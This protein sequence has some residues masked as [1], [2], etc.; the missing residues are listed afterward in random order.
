MHEPITQDTIDQVSWYH[1]F[2]FGNGLRTKPTHDIDFHR[3]VWKFIETRLDA[4]EFQGKTVLDI[5]CWDGYWSFYAERRGASHV[6]ASDDVTQNWASG[7]GLRLAK[8]LLR[9]EVEVNQRLPIYELASLGRRFDIVLCLGIYYHLVD[10]FYALA[11]IRHVCHEGSVVVIE[12]DGAAAGVNPQGT[13]FDLSDHSKPIFV[14]TPGAL[15]HMCEGAYLAVQSQ[16][17]RTKAAEF[18]AKATPKEKAVAIRRSTGGPQKSPSLTDPL[19]FDRLVTVC[20]A[21]TGDNS[22]HF[23]KPPF[24]LHAYDDRF[25]GGVDKLHG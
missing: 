22:K 17:W 8:Q 18:W 4:V 9:S 13:L 24:G 1:E 2:D 3:E 19:V 12:G 15:A 16:H 10:P 21:F 6:L 5:G 11:Q 20:R 7:N 23:Y 14:P 25:K